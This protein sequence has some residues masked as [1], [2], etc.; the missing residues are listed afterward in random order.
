MRKVF[1]VL[2]VAA[3]AFFISKADAQ[4]G[5]AVD[6]K[7]HKCADAAV[8]KF[9]TEWRDKQNEFKEL[10]CKEHLKA[11]SAEECDDVL[12]MLYGLRQLNNEVSSF[13]IKKFVVPTCGPHPKDP[14]R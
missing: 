14:N 4:E 13:I 10:F 2:A 8:R 12:A 11:K 9:D 7:W 1:Y 6:K 5:S 3:V